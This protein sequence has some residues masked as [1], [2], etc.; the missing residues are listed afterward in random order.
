MGNWTRRE[1]LRLGAIGGLVLVKPSSGL[2][3]L[4]SGP[5]RGAGGPSTGSPPTGGYL[6]LPER[7]TL[8][9]AV[10]RV[11]PSSGPGDWSA[12]DLGVVDYIDGLLSGF[13]RHRSSGAI[14]PGGPYRIPSGSGPGFGVFR[15]LSRVKSIGWRRQ[16]KKWR[17]LYAEGLAGLDGATLGNFAAAPELQQDLVLLDLDLSGSPFFA[18]LFDHTME[19]TYSHPV[20]GGNRDFKAWQWLGFGGDVHGVRF[21]KVGSHGSWNIYGGYSPEEIIQPGSAA[22]EQPVLTPTA[23][24]RG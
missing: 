3:N 22:T 8:A 12:A 14:Y 11:V 6:S 17:S 9:A 16:V 21:P 7:A 19:G 13:D 1:F 15:P 24:R 10:A 4:V 2:V 23:T 18:V 20:Y 5:G